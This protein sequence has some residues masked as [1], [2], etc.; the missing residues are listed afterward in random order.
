MNEV[1]NEFLN[2][3]SLLIEEAKKNVKTAVNIAMVYT[4]FE[5]GRMIIM[6]GYQIHLSKITHT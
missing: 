3:V 4:Y 5:I 2:K 1:S 6:I